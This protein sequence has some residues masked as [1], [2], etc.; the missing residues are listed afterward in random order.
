MQLLLVLQ[1]LRLCLPWLFQPKF[2]GG[3]GLLFFKIIMV[4]FR[5]KLSGNKV[6]FHYQHDIDSMKFHDGYE[7]VE[8]IV[9][10]IDLQK[11][12]QEVVKPVK[13]RPRKQ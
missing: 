9:E 4:T 6:T 5:C 13:G 8:D 3:F 10:V 2:E 12:T 7:R 11:V 1:G